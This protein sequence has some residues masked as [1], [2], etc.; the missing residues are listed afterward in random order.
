MTMVL[1]S[2]CAESMC[3]TLCKGVSSSNWYRIVTLPCIVFSLREFDNGVERGR[4][5][6]GATASM[7]RVDVGHSEDVY[8]LERL[9]F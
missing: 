2:A 1:C 3:R 6:E 7:P 8:D 9:P 4:S 5:A